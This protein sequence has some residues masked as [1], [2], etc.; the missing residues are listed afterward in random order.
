MKNNIQLA[1]NSKEKNYYSLQLFEVT[2]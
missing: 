2:I 1:I